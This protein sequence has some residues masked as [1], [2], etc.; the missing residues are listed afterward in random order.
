[1]LLEKGIYYMESKLTNGFTLDYIIENMGITYIYKVRRG[2]VSKIKGVQ[3]YYEVIYADLGFILKEE[4]VF[5]SLVKNVGEIFPLGNGLDAESFAIDFKYL[6]DFSD[7]R[8]SKDIL[9]EYSLGVG[10]FYTWNFEKKDFE[11]ITDKKFLAKQRRYHK[12]KHE[13]LDILKMY[14]EVRKT[15]IAQDEQVKQVLASVYKNQR[16]I[17]S[18][19]D[20]ETITKLKENIIVYG[21]S[22]TGKTEILT[23]IAKLCNVPIVI[24]DATSFSETGYVGRDVSDMLSDLYSMAG[25]D[26]E[27]AQKGILVIDE[28]DK[29]AEGGDGGNVEGPSRSGVQRSLLKLLDGGVINFREDNYDGNRIDFNTSKL[30]VVALGA[31]SGIKKDDNYSDISTKDFIDYGIMR[32]VMGRFSKLVSMNSFSKEEFKKILIESNLSPLNTYKKLFEEM[33][34]NF[35]YDDDLIDYIADEAVAL[36]CGARSLKTVFDGIISDYLFDLFSGSKKDIHLTKPHDLSH[37][38]Q[39]KKLASEKRKMVGFH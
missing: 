16:I 38:H 15:I 33:G 8:N 34:I 17:N 10:K 26:L 19:L 29:I 39:A 1:M 35:S 21:P 7:V 2:V 22:G 20:D 13:D 6:S 9:K 32:E 23:Q 11:E 36:D 4:G 5:I 27:L 25:M 37:S 18:S 14:G 28:F 31:F 30:T 3:D 12:V 24:E